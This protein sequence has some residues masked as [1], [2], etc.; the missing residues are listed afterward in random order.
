MAL[1]SELV[2]VCEDHRVDTGSTL[3]LFAR[4]LRE[5]GRISKAG[6]GRG[7]AH[8]TFLDAARFLI[9][10]LATDRPEQ[11]A[12][13]E[14]VNSNL[15]LAHGGQANDPFLIDDVKTLD[16]AFAL[17]LEHLAHGKMR[18][19][20]DAKWKEEHPIAP[21]GATHVWLHLQREG[22]VATLRFGDS[23]YSFY[24]P[25]LKALTEPATSEERKLRNEAYEREL[26]RFRT[27]KNITAE[28]KLDLLEAVG[29][30]IAGDP[31]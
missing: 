21:I 3:N 7:A 30:L 28:F 18:S 4:R 25:A 31:E 29:T 12:D 26:H 13:A 23:N 22:G 16:E 8:M 5:A 6:R 15:V 24:H 17:A 11:A 14:Y 10:C 20:Y 2:A 9:A 19:H 27:G 1:L